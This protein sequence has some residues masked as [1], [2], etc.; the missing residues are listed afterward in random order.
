MVA[1]IVNNLPVIRRA[2]IDPWVRKIPWR[3]YPLQYSCLEN[4]IDRVAWQVAVHG[5]AK[6][7]T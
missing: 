7:Q 6:S 2:R 1:Q 3:R 5:F 4:S